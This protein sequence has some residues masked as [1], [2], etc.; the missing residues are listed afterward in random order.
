[1][2][3]T[4]RVLA[5]FVGT[6]PIAI[7]FTAAVCRFFPLGAELRFAWGFGFS[8]PVWVGLVCAFFLARSAWRSWALCT[9][10]TAGLA[11]FVYGIPV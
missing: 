1:M 11:L 8:F 7:L 9:A 5:A 10:M 3:D 4:F 6:L 2:A